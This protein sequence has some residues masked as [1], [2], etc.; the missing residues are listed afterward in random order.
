MCRIASSSVGRCAV[1]V[2]RRRYSYSDYFCVCAIFIDKRPG[3]LLLQ[4]VASTN[5]HGIRS[6]GAEL[7]CLFIDA[8]HSEHELNAEL[9]L[10]SMP[11]GFIKVCRFQCVLSLSRSP[12]V[13]GAQDGADEARM[14][15]PPSGAPLRFGVL[16]CGVWLMRRG[17]TSAGSCSR[18]A[19]G[20]RRRTRCSSCSAPCWALSA[21]P[22]ASPSGGTCSSAACCRCCSPPCACAS[23]LAVRAPPSVWPRLVG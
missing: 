7:V 4:L 6:L 12:V 19:T 13:W 5:K 2:C 15:L 22:P 9:L 23:A 8:L 21:R 3:S 11:L 18:S 16:L 14:P 10:A 20:R 1:L 17:Q